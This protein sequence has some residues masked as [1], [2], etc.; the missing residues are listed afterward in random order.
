MVVYE[1]L[2][3]ISLHKQ[4]KFAGNMEELPLAKDLKTE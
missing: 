1:D 4:I 3:L 2:R